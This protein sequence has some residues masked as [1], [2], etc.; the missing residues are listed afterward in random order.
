M[1]IPGA[2]HHHRQLA[3]AE[4]VQR[5]LIAQSVWH[6]AMTE[7]IRQPLHIGNHPWL[8]GMEPQPLLLID[9]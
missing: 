4:P 7:P 5:Q 1:G 2:T 8:V 6:P 3:L 9:P